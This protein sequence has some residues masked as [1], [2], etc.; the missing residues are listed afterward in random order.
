MS[1]PANHVMANPL[2]GIEVPSSDPLSTQIYHSL[3][4]S[5]FDKQREF[6]PRDCL[7]RLVT[8]DTIKKELELDDVERAE[9]IWLCET[10]QVELV[11][12][13]QSKARIVFAITIYCDY[14]AEV[15]IRLMHRF[16]EL[17][18]DDT[19]LPVKNP[20]AVADSTESEAQEPEYFDP[21]F[22]TPPKRYNF[23]QKQW[24][25]LVPVFKSCQYNYDLETGRVFPFFSDGRKP[26]EGAFSWVHK[27]EIHS[28]HQDYP[29][30]NYVSN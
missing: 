8:Q 4:D 29:G 19:R 3:K 28:A 6:L 9:K 30:L 2:I 16:Q 17:E 12:W 21:K 7:E 27:V 25:C 11:Q 14:S 18:F 15:T 24:L 22:W 5:T 1:G 20:K 13:I 10:C 23:Y 26:K